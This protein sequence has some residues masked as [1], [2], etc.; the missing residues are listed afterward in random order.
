MK[1]AHW[2]ARRVRPPAFLGQTDSVFAGNDSAPSEDLCKEI[3]ERALHFFAHSCIPVKA[4]GHDVDV[5]VAVTGMP[6][7]GDRKAVL[8]VEPLREFYK[9][10]N[11][12]A[13]ND[14]I[15]VQF[16][17]AGRSQ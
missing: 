17:Q 7:A 5:N 16:G 1:L 4:V 8:R 12:A 9:I 3:V 15:L 11:S 6:K 13:G 14:H 2:L 10:D